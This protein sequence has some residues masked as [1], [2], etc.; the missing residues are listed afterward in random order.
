M[1]PYDWWTGAGGNDAGGLRFD[2]LTRTLAAKSPRRGMLAG[3]LGGVLGAAGFGIR[4]DAAAACTAL[5]RGRSSGVDCC[6]GTCA[7]GRCACPPGN[8]PCGG[9]QCAPVCPPGQSRGSGCRCLCRNT[10]REPGPFG[11]PCSESS[12]C[13]GG[14][15]VFCGGTQ[16][17]RLC[18]TAASGALVCSDFFAP[19]DVPRDTDADCPANH[20][21]PTSFDCAQ[22]FRALTRGGPS[23]ARR[24]GPSPRVR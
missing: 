16:F 14:A 3:L 20:T 10:G 5:Y 21:C 15:I 2:Q 6:S 8:E 13:D 11:C 7:D 22:G 4:H 1:R 24:S 23:A 18:D 17:D 12:V 19:V 9:N